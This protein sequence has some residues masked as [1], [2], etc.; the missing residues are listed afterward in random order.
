MKSTV[1]QTVKQL[2]CMHVCNAE[3]HTNTPAWIV[4]TLSATWRRVSW[5]SAAYTTAVPPPD[6]EWAGWDRGG[7]GW[8]GWVGVGRNGQEW[9]GGRFVEAWGAGE[10]SLHHIHH[11][12]AVEWVGTWAGM[13]RSG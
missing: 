5:S 1:K 13:G 3:L 8:P 7:R 2:T 4:H 6:R 11:R 10:L 12:S 9:L